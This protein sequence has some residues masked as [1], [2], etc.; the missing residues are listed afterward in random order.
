MPR[1]KIYFNRNFV[2][3]DSMGIT[4]RPRSV[5]IGG[6]DEKLIRERDQVV[7]RIRRE[8]RALVRESGWTQ[9]RVEEANGFTAGYL[10][11]VLKGHITLTVRHLWGILM[12]IGT[13][14]GEFLARVD[15]R[16]SA[17]ELRERMDRYEAL[18]DRLQRQ[19]VTGGNPKRD[20]E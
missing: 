11:Q 19:V 15:G 20:D 10:S 12:A 1:L 8:L 18:L 14:P 16:S 4:P 6:V 13:E 5:T 2:M 9:R 3:D 17:D 7:D